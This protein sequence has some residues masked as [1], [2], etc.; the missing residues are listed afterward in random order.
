MSSQRYQFVSAVHL[1]LI[2]DNQVLLARRFNTGYEDGQDSLPAGHI[3]QGEPAIQAIIREVKEELTI[4][5]EKKNLEVVHVMHRNGDDHERIDFFM[6]VKKW[7]GEPMIG[8]P[9]KCDR[10]VWCALDNL[11]TNTIAYIKTALH[12]IH[13]NEF[14]SEFGW[15]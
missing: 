7:S 8:E 14:Y 15:D 11:P 3:D 12:K 6:K 1:L 4:R 13:N 10:L 9:D 2:K 5:V